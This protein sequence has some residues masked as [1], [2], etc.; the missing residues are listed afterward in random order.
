MTSPLARIR[1]GAVEPLERGADVVELVGP[2]G[3]VG[4]R[5]CWVGWVGAEAV[6]DGGDACYLVCWVVEKGRQG[7]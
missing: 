2:F 5:V 3:A 1:G 4:G 6:V 7:R